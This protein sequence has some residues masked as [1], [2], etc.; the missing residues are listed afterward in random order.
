VRTGTDVAIL[1]VGS[2]VLP[3]ERAA[4]LLQAEGI[5]A[6][7]VN[8]RFVKPLDKRLIKSLAET[9]GALVTVEENARAGG[10]GSAVLEALEELGNPVPIRT[11]GVPDRVFEQASQ[12]RLRELAGLTASDIADAAR[13]VL[14]EKPRFRSLSAV[15]GTNRV[16]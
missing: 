8:A 13:A 6:T 14:T 12:G 10:F 9:D 3:S 2:M 15:A 7:V 5:R 16:G 11:L 4:D 1:A